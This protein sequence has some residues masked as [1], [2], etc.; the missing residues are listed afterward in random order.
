[1]SGLTWSMNS[2]VIGWAEFSPG[3]IGSTSKIIEMLYG[4][5]KSLTE[6]SLVTR[7]MEWHFNLLSSQIAQVPSVAAAFCRW[8]I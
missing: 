6:N 7:L 3:F 5:A 8:M 4:L 1:M 2:V